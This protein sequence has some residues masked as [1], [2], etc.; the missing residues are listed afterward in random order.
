M[1][2]KTGLIG[3]RTRSHRRDGALSGTGRCDQVVFLT[4]HPR[5]AAADLVIWPGAPPTASPANAVAVAAIALATVA[6]AS[7]L[8]AR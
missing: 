1:G 4:P 8:A 5:L 7:L 6:R 3:P 2:G